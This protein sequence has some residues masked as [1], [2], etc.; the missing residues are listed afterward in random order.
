M[1][2]F[3]GF[4]KAKLEK[5]FRKNEWVI[6]QSIPFLQLEQL[7]VE[8][9]ESGGEI[10]DDYERLKPDTKKWECELRKG[11]SILTCIWMAQHQGLIYGPERVLSGLAE[12]LNLKPS[13]SLTYT[14]F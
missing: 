13:S 3:T 5:K 14:W 6:I 1:G 12:K 8:H 10:E 7:I 9:V 4:K 11:T 2:L